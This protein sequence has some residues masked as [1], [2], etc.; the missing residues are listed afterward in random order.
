MPIELSQGFRFGAFTAEPLKGSVTR[1]NG[2]S[3]HLPPKAMDVLVRLAEAAPYPVT[4]DDLI[5]AVWGERYVS[6]EVLTHA[7]KEL[8]HALDDSPTRPQYIQTIPKRG[9]RLLKKARPI[10]DQT[11]ARE[12]RK[13]RYLVIAASLVLVFVAWGWI[14][15]DRLPT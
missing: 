6:D 8:R 2:Q 11:P 3:R 9:Y 12:G 10:G 13:R 7:I 14:V 5:T 4:R 1:D 15:V